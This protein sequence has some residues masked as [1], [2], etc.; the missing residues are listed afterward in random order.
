MKQIAALCS[1]STG[2]P[3][4]YDIKPYSSFGESVYNWKSAYNW[5]LE[6]SFNFLDDTLFD[7]E[8]LIISS[9]S[10]ESKHTDHV[11][12]VSYTVSEDYSNRQKSRNR[13]MKLLA[14][15]DG[16]E[17][18]ALTRNA[19]DDDSTNDDNDIDESGIEDK[20][21][22]LVMTQADVSRAKAIKALRNNENDIVNAIMELSV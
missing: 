9:S 13:D 17:R 22:E 11:Q 1:P 14:L 16:T 4:H 2:P 7:V 15:R 12:T 19:V 3:W 10:K 20:D 8:S 5:G 21:I 6:S 18:R